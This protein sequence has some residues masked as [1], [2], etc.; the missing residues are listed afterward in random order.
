MRAMSLDSHPRR[1]FGDCALDEFT[2]AQQFERTFDPGRRQHGA[3][4]AAGS[5]T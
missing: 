1:L 5:V 2:G 3:R 4:S